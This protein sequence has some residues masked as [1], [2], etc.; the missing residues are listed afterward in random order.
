[1]PNDLVLFSTKECPKCTKLSEYLSKMGI[2]YV[3]RMID[4]DPDA[5]TDALMHNI[6]AAPALIK[7]DSVLRAKDLFM[8]N[9]IVEEKLKHFVSN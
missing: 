7:G 3:K 4:S 9:N 1:M 2:K 8:N 5:E 6:F